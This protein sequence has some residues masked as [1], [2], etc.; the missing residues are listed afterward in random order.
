MHLCY[1]DYKHRHFTVPADLS[2]C[3]ELANGVGGAADFVHMPAD[4][5]SAATRPTTSH[6]AI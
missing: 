3:V 5:D 6:C 1:G 4:R 2:L